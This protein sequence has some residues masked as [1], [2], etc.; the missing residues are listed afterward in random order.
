[1]DWGP[2]LPGVTVGV[3]VLLVGSAGTL[4]WRWL[5]RRAAGR[6]VDTAKI[7]PTLMLAVSHGSV[8][9]GQVESGATVIVN[10]VDYVDGVAASKIGEVRR[11]FEV[12]RAHRSR[13][14][15]K[16][17]IALFQQCVDMEED[18][19]R[20]NAL[21]IQIGNCLSD[22]S[23][24]LK[25][26]ESYAVALEE[27]RRIDDRHAKAVALVGIGNTYVRRRERNPSAEG[28][29]V[30]SAVRYYEQ[31]LTVFEAEKYAVDYALAQNNLGGAYMYLPAGTSRERAENVE[32]AIAYFDAARDIYCR[33][34]YKDEHQLDYAM[35]LQ[36]LGAAYVNLPAGA[37]DERME[38]ATTAVRYLEAARDIY[39]RDEYKDQ[40]RL[41]F[42]FMQYHLGWAYLDLPVETTD[43]RA[44]NLRKAEQ[45]C[46]ALDVFLEIGYLETYARMQ[47]NL[48]IAYGQFP[49]RTPRE[50]EEHAKKAM[51]YLEGA[52]DILGGGEHPV[53]NAKVQ[54]NLGNARMDL[55]AETAEEHAENVHTAIEQ[56]HN[57][58]TVF[59]IEEYPA[60]YAMVQSNLGI[61]Y[62]TLLGGAPE[63]QREN[64]HKAIGCFE[65]AVEIYRKSENP[66]EYSLTASR[67]AVAYVHVDRDRARYWLGEADLH[68]GLTTPGSP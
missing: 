13:R 40:H 36:S 68:L 4:A 27:A 63:G 16:E 37:D 47:N 43:E 6:S 18:H 30:R 44:A 58:L 31:A 61:A 55:P 48:A 54:M 41:G 50:R 57:A 11:L 24:H 20:L 12:A 15:F 53:L 59:S 65:A 39:C 29:N 46:A 64:A 66:R 7:D 14:E 10:V 38:H 22:L 67:L 45:C 1:M 3:T 9:I 19:L 35:T 42:A 21:H 56:Y 17:A 25:A 49:A 62:L 52:L 33:D 2:Y 32:R 8:S 23:H 60:D 51:A 28:E 26:E 5:R 34:E